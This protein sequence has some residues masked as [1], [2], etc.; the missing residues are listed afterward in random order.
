V[1][2]ERQLLHDARLHLGLHHRLPVAQRDLQVGEGEGCML[3]RDEILALHLEQE[4]EHGRIEHLPGADL[5]LDHVEAR[6]L[7]V[8]AAAA[9]T[10][11]GGL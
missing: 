9:L 4:L 7:D 10:V 6:L 2:L 8:H 1:R 11:K 5:L 3:R